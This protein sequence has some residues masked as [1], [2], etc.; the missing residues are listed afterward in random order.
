MKV[1][2]KID[3]INNIGYKLFYDLDS[4]KIYSVISKIEINGEIKFYRIIDELKET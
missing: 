4:E 3:T 1:K 2:L